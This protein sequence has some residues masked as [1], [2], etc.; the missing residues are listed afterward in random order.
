MDATILDVKSPLRKFG[1][2]RALIYRYTCLFSEPGEVVEVWKRA[3]RSC[4]F[5][6][7]LCTASEPIANLMN[8]ITR[9]SHGGIVIS[10]SFALAIYHDCK[11]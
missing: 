2:S 5:G 10:E 1:K 9:P 11:H 6:M 4:A 7:R 8:R 3:S